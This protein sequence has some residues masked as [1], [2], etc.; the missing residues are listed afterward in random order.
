MKKCVV[1]KLYGNMEDAPKI[2]EPFTKVIPVDDGRMQMVIAENRRLNAL[3]GVRS[4]GDSA[5]RQTADFCNR[6]LDK[7]RHLKE[8]GVMAGI[9]DICLPVP[10]LH[11]TALYI[12]LK[13]RK[14]GRVSEA[15]KKVMYKLTKYGN[16]AVVCYGWEE[17]RDTILN[18]LRQ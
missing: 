10:S 3:N 16:I 12:E 8:K 13:R 11:H 1:V 9:P 7:G 14:G 15:Q 4:Y 6:Y 2:A 5:W 17:A 18:Y